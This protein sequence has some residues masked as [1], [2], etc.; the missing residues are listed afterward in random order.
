MKKHS[1]DIA[2]RNKKIKELYQHH[3][4]IHKLT[5]PGALARIQNLY[6]YLAKET[7]YYIIKH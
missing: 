3:R 1:P 2:D 7:I 4:K 6:P 5:K